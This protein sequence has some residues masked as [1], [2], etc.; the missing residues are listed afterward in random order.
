MSVHFLELVP[1]DRHHRRRSGQEHRGHPQGVTDQSH[2][3]GSNTK[4]AYVQDSLVSQVSFGTRSDNGAPSFKETG[5]RA[6][7]L[8]NERG[9]AL[10]V[11]V[12]ALVVIGAL[13]AG[14]VLRGAAGAADRPERLHR[15]RPRRRR[16]GRPRS[17]SSS[18]DGEHADR[19]SRRGATPPAP[20]S[21]W[22]RGSRRPDHPLTSSVWLVSA[23][24]ER[25]SGT[26][27]LRPGASASSTGSTRPTSPSTPASPP[28]VRSPWAAT[29]K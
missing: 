7:R 27:S 12:F 25:K 24:G 18:S 28:S 13:V 1:A 23:I 17:T 10:A 15:C 6:S 5:M 20:R 29:R 19:R 11:A 14:D 9:M 22:A 16:R 2:R 26:K 8:P 3:R 4:T 21:R